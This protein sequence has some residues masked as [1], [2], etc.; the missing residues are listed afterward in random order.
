LNT[1]DQNKQN[2]QNTY[3]NVKSTAMEALDT[4]QNSNNQIANY[5]SS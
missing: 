3:S 1:I 5:T 2:I 4:A